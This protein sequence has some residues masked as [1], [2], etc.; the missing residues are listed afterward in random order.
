TEKDIRI[1]D[2]VLVEKAGEIIPQIHSVVLG[3][4]LGDAVIFAM[5]HSCP[6][7]H[8]DTFTTE[9]PGE[10]ERKIILRFCPNHI[11]P[12]QH[13]ARIVHFASREAMDIEGMG[14]AVVEWLLAERLLKD[15]SD[16]YRLAAKD[17]LPMTKQG[18]DLLGSAGDDAEPTKM[19]ENLTTAILTSK[20]R[21]LAKL[22][23]ALSIPNIGETAAQILARSYK[24]LERLRTAS[25]E[26]IAATPMGESA[27]YRTL[28][29]KSAAILDEA[30]PKLDPDDR[31]PG[32]TPEDLA[33]FLEGLRLR[34]F[35][36]KKC[37]AIAKH[38][39]HIDSL[40]KATRTEL[41][42]TE[43]GTSQ[44]KRTLGDVVAKSLKA[45]LA[46]PANIGIIE[47]LAEAGVTMTDATAADASPAAGKVF[48]LTGTLPNLSRVEAKRRIEASGGIVAGG[49]SRK[50]DYL[51]AG[52]DPGSKLTKAGKLGI[53][54]IDETTLLELLG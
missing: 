26:E 3:K 36:K 28:G 51:A 11:C 8:S 41:A 6:V 42:M 20:K 14:P 45:F 21:G 33:R 31:P 22:L 47:R 24:S 32:N 30:L 5:P 43:M 53:K 46:N 15:V 49:I 44:I 35:G 29:D 23:F 18:R 54:I 2:Q 52:D 38:F 10:G 34:Q 39:G 7:C 48:V 13:L 17:L 1:G 25:K 40:L 50:V 37:Q 12:A 9:R 16:I 27:A 4:R 19:A